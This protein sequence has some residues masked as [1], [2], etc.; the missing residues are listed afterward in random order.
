MIPKS[1]EGTALSALPASA[2]ARFGASTTVSV[3]EI[4][5]P[6]LGTHEA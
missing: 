3:E 4:M 2:A 1:V 5:R 6:F